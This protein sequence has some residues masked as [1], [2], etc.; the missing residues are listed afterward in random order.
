MY[1]LRL[2]L[3]KL[4]PFKKESASLYRTNYDIE[5][6]PRVGTLCFKYK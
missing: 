4:K 6:R 5:Y 2:K 3:I 1:Q